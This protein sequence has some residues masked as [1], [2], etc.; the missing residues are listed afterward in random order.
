MGGQKGS[1]GLKG[2]VGSKGENGITGNKGDN[3]NEGGKGEQGATG[4]D[5]PCGVHGGNSI[6]FVT[7]PNTAAGPGEINLISSSNNFNLITSIIVSTQDV[8]FADISN[9]LS[10]LANGVY[11]R[12]ADPCDSSRY[13][14]YIIDSQSGSGGLTHQFNVSLIVATG[15]FIASGDYL[16]KTIAGQGP[17]GAKGNQGSTGSTGDKGQKGDSG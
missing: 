8:H 2:E 1:D 11:I 15:S 17:T 5:G 14:I 7:T 6:M 10:T 4:S 13:G 16:I 12:L 3:G 9:W